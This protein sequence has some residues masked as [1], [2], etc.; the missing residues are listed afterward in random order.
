MQQN[1]E[2]KWEVGT[3]GRQSVKDLYNILGKR[4]QSTC[5]ALMEFKEVTT[6]EESQLEELRLR[7]T[8]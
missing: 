4:L 1:K 2:R 8:E 5:V 7:C 3:G 6:S